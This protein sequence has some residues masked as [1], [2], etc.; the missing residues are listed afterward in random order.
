MA[1]T[2]LI[3]GMICGIVAGL[4]VFVYA[5]FFGEPSVDG[6]IG[7]EDLLAHIS[8]EGHHDEVELV[9]R[10]LQSTWGLFSGVMLYAIA[11]G[12]LF[13]LLSAFAWG[14]MGTLGARAGSAL[15][16][17][18]SFVAVYLVPFF[19]YP[20]T[21]PSVGNPDTIQYRT[22]LYFGMI[23]IS[24]AGMVAAI[25]LAHALVGRLSTWH[26]ALA[27]GAVYFAVVAVAYAILPPINEVPEQF[28][29]VL[30]W[31]F[32]TSSLT[33]QAILWAALGLLFG[34][35]TAR[36]IERRSPHAVRGAATA[37]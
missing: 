10:D 15:L 13:S 2:F 17:G 9:S 5:R 11:L 33:M 26:A 31:S 25:S 34:E 14:R 24:I 37:K 20:A 16:A 7:V 21:P 27:G 29:A 28:P 8:G 3:R 35:L 30:L 1:R 18:A 12:G 36:R 22:A 19:K 32:R 6:A 23:V 4:L